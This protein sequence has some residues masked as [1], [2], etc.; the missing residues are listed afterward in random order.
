MNK[1]M[2]NECSWKSELSCP[3][4]AGFEYGCLVDAFWARQEYCL[5]G[6][7]DVDI[8]EHE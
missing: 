2:C 8:S 1:K 3:I 4:M 6:W 7:D 5:V